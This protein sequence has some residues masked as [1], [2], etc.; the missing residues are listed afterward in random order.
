MKSA[1]QIGQESKVYHGGEMGNLRLSPNFVYT[2]L[3]FIIHCDGFL[4]KNTT[5][6]TQSVQFIISIL[7][8]GSLICKHP[9]SLSLKKPECSF[10]IKIYNLSYN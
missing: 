5:S 4:R 7:Y 10:G 8:S 1:L 9:F 2:L 3:D 6:S